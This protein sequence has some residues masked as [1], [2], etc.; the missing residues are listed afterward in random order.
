MVA[1]FALLSLAACRSTG[2]PVPTT[3]SP[4]AEAAHDEDAGAVAAPSSPPDAAPQRSFPLPV[5]GNYGAAEVVVG[6][7][8]LL[9]VD[10]RNARGEPDPRTK[11][12]PF[13]CEFMLAARLKGDGPTYS[14]VAVF[15]G[16]S[17]RATV[18]VE[19]MA[20]LR[21]RYEGEPGGCVS[22]AGP[23]L[24]GGLDAAGLPL[25][26]AGDGRNDTLGFRAIAAPRAFF[27]A[28]TDAPATTTYV[29]KGDVVRVKAE[30]PGWVQVS[31]ERWSGKESTGWL[32][33]DDLFPL[34]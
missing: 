16:K 1:T 14:G 21:I 30:S 22:T 33:T 12:P 15:D 3:Q 13:T 32:R 11:V 24:G 27:H 26:R 9:T 25:A 18:T 7:G 23:E 10:Y 29:L 5:S 20:V 17:H 2:V 28:R 4:D 6:A 34:P 19:A 8:R 31:Y